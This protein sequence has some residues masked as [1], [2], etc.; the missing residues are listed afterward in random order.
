MA[1]DSAAARYVLDGSDEDLRRLL[2]ISALL[3]AM[4]RT[5]LA[6]VDIRPGW[7]VLECG[8]GPLGAMPI[9]SDLVGPS[10]QVVGADFAAPTV[11]RA[12]S[13]VTEL[14]LRNV[15]VRVADIN[16]PASSIGDS[17]DLVFSRCFLLHQRD[18]LRTLT[19]IRDALRPGGWFVAMEPLPNPPPFSFPPH[20]D[21]RVA[22]ELL[23]RAIERGGASPTAIDDLPATAREAG[24]DV[25]RLGGSFQ[26]ADPAT[27]F[28]LH[29][30][31]T[32]A[33]RAQI[34]ASGV[35]T[36]EEVD[37]VIDRLHTAAQGGYHWVTSPLSLTVTLRAP[38]P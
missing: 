24:F 37:G 19:R 33:V 36:S 7:R 10:G 2:K 23:H 11:A 32:V 3:D 4:T 20:D 9:L 25:V 26:P 13:V 6:T 8:C 15:E 28:G 5:A 34:I 1:T 31:T 38:G 12:R 30:A 22:W 18:P 17:Y 14:G 21:L 35:A 29:A 16:D 27:G